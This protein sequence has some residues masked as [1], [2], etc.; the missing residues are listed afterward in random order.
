MHSHCSCISKRKLIKWLI[1]QVTDVWNKSI[2]KIVRNNVIRSITTKAG[3][4]LLCLYRYIREAM[5]SL[6]SVVNI[7]APAHAKTGNSQTISF[8][9]SPFLWECMWGVVCWVTDRNWRNTSLCWDFSI[10]LPVHV[11]LEA[12]INDPLR[13]SVIFPFLIFQVDPVLLSPLRAVK[14]PVSWEGSYGWRELFFK[15]KWFAGAPKVHWRPAEWHPWHWAC[16]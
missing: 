14:E 5:I 16:M 15:I 9:L 8:F 4:L 3:L 1:L 6:V 10:P 2:A 11:G 13:L 7:W 12:K